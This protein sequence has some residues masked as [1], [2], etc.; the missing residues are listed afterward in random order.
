MNLKEFICN[1]F[2]IKNYSDERIQITFWGIKLRIQKREV[3]KIKKQNPYY[4]YKK[5]KLDI[6]T[7]PPATGQLRDIQLANLALLVEF[8][9]VCKKANLKYWLDWGSLIGAVRHKG[10]IPWDDDIDV[11][12]LRNDY[13]L[14]LKQFDSLKQNKD[15]YLEVC[16]NLHEY[17]YLLKLKH[18]KCPH[19]F[20]DIFPSFLYGDIL[21]IS[22]QVA[23]TKRMKQERAKHFR[24]HKQFSC[25]E[26]FFASMDEIQS[27]V[28]KNN[29]I[30]DSDIVLGLDFKHYNKNFFHPY[31]QV[32]PLKEVEFEGFSFPTVNNPDEYLKVFYGDY[33]A[34]PRKISLG[35]NGY[36]NLS[37]QDKEVIKN[38]ILN[39]TAQGE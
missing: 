28:L 26:D 30:E 22:E 33:M 34:Y 6:T 36:K 9:Y 7:V 10:Y 17:S 16:P 19:L 13:D 27:K 24:K 5:N 2:S 23:V 8:D 32:F 35:H 31:K 15:V 38:L 29:T 4:Y 39:L 37:P 18:K 12:M 3:A 21:N 25:K 1:I 11:G 20:I 14:L